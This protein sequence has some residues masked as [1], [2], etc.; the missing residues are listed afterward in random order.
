[1]SNFKSMSTEQLIEMGQTARKETDLAT[2]NMVAAE[3]RR[4]YWS[5]MRVR[6]KRCQYECSWSAA[7]HSRRHGRVCPLC[8]YDMED[9][10][11]ADV[12]ESV[13]TGG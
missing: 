3:L 11:P 1:M 4:R 7:A 10:P 2:G 8:F 12:P 5:G 6:C 13:P 9:V